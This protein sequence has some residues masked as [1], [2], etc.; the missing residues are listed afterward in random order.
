MMTLTGGADGT[1]KMPS[2]PI[3][4]GNILCAC[5]AYGGI[6]QRTAGRSS[7]AVRYNKYRIDDELFPF[8]GVLDIGINMA[9]VL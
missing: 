8:A 2:A 6:A 3:S 4:R 5:P 9:A 1:P 7:S